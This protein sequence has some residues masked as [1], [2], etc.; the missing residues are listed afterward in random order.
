MQAF[1]LHVLPACLVCYF[2]GKEDQFAM[3]HRNKDMAIKA[4]IL[5]RFLKII[6]FVPKPPFLRSLTTEK[7]F[8]QFHFIRQKKTKKLRYI[9]TLK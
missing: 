7:E 8:A 5:I 1:A 6:L 9:E 3:C 2:I 4:R